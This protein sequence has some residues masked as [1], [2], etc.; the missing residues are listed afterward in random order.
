[1]DEVSA[2][3]S[4]SAPATGELGAQLTALR[5]RVET[6]RQAQS[7]PPVDLLVHDL[8]TAYE[9]LRA[10]DEELR[11]QQDQLSEIQEAH[12][13]ARLQQ[14]RIIAMIPVPVLITD[15]N[16]VVRAVNAAAAMLVGMRV[17]RMVGKPIFTLFSSIDQLALRGGVAA[18]YRD[19]ATFR[20]R[21]TLVRRPGVG[22]P[23]DVEVTASVHGL[24]AVDGEINWMLL[25]RVP[26][27]GLTTGGHLSG[28]FAELAI[29]PT[30]LTTV[31][32]VLDAAAHICRSAMGRSVE[33]SIALGSPAEP[34]AVSSS[35]HYAQTMDGAQVAAAQGPSV[36]AF[37]E[38]T[39][40]AVA[41]PS[42][43]AR[44]PAL[45]RYLPAD[46]CPVLATSVEVGERT[47]GALTI[48]RADLA[49]RETVELL[50]VT[51]GAVIN[52]LD[53]KAELEQLAVD[54]ERA[55]ASRSVIDQ[56]L[57]IVMATRRVGPETAWEHLVMLSSTQHT[58]VRQ[59]AQMIVDQASRQDE[60]TVRSRS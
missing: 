45:A 47:T 3:P 36:T 50:A 1:M 56:A 32:E 49:R 11:S 55:L 6:A 13:A 33:V 8:E 30:R 41:D 48:Y 14:E 39:T 59:V 17:A 38:A 44:W 15:L 5:L 54:M 2:P 26:G 10:A 20:R 35:S 43:D 12:R 21:A 60:A 31:T 40:V 16:G 25:D 19:G 28:A 53:L 18:I 7:A 52:E 4:R 29:L 34:D 57:G 37:L 51:I 22:D 9:E 42:T 24:H 46:R 23:V 27:A 58:K